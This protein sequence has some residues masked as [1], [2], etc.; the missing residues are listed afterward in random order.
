MGQWTPSAPPQNT[1]AAADISRLDNPLLGR[2]DRKMNLEEKKP[3]RERSEQKLANFS[4]TF[5]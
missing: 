2:S 1:E 5:G 4:L 3:V